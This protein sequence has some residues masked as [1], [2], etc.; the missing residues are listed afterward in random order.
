CRAHPPFAEHLA[1]QIR[2][3]NVNRA[4]YTMAEVSEGS[5]LNSVAPLF[6]PET[7]DTLIEAQ[8]ALWEGRRTYQGESVLRTLSGRRV[9]VMINVSFPEDT[10]RQPVVVTLLDIS[11]QK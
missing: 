1:K 4:L 3:L 10:S 8:N 5:Q 6:L 9:A 11:E 2:V 7:L